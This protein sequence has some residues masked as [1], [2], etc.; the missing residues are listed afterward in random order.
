MLVDT[1]RPLSLTDI[2]PLQSSK[3]SPLLRVLHLPG[4]ASSWE[5]EWAELDQKRLDEKAVQTAK[6]EMETD[7]G[8]FLRAKRVE[9]RA[10]IAMEGVSSPLSD[11]LREFTEE[12]SDIRKSVQACRAGAPWSIYPWGGDKPVDIFA[13]HEGPV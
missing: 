11:D 8:T 13:A 12:D 7:L 1:L 3:K 2:L 4:L 9:G 10:V 6:L 5:E